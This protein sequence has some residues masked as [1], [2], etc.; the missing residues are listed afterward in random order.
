MNENVNRFV[1]I[2]TGFVGSSYTYSLVN[3]GLLK[4]MKRRVYQVCKKYK[5]S[6]Q[7]CL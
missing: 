6:K 2:G 3:Q 1:L 4:I 5:Y 7:N